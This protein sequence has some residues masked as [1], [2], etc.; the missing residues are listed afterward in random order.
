MKSDSA[1]ACF[2][3]GKRHESIGVLVLLHAYVCLKP[4]VS[5]SPPDHLK[6]SLQSLLHPSATTHSSRSPPSS[7]IYPGLIQSSGR[8]VC[9][10][11]SLPR[12]PSVTEQC[13]RTLRHPGFCLRTHAR[14]HTHRN[15]SAATLG[16]IRGG[17]GHLSHTSGCCA[18]L[19]GLVC[20]TLV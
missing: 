20:L 2:I 3:A 14:T 11:G 1:A 4:F 16:C 7:F 9:R 13:I 5:S 6:P 15:Q 10:K 8:S 19:A 17:E 12:R 18:H